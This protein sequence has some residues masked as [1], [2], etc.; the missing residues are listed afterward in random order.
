MPLCLALNIRPGRRRVSFADS[1]TPRYPWWST[2]FFVLLGAG[3][4]I[5]ALGGPEAVIGLRFEPYVLFT[6]GALAVSGAVL[7][8]GLQWRWPGR[9]GVN[10]NVFVGLLVLGL[11]AAG[12][13]R[14]GPPLMRAVI[15]GLYGGLSVAAALGLQWEMHRRPPS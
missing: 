1:M 10:P 11:V 15:F 12:I 3:F 14:S 5:A 9:V 6:A 13:A 8:L 4:L 2:P 7:E